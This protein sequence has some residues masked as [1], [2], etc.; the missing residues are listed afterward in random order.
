MKMAIND[1]LHNWH[2]MISFSQTS[3]TPIKRIENGHGYFLNIPSNSEVTLLF[4]FPLPSVGANEICLH[5]PERRWRICGL[6][7][8]DGPF[9]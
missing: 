9:I 4:T 6:R 5:G 7:I 2:E 1:Q 3:G 8:Y